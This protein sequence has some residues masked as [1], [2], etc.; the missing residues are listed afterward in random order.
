[1]LVE[2]DAEPTAVREALGAAA[3]GRGRTLVLYG[4]PGIGKSALLLQAV[5]MAP[6]TVLT[7]RGTETESEL[8]FAGL[9]DLLTP[10][11]HLSSEL[12]PP[13]RRAL[14]GALAIEDTG[15]VELFG[16]YAGALT[17][18]SMA[19]EREPLLLCIDDVQWLDAGSAGAL[20]FVAG[21][22]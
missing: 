14:L 17:V 6:G 8:P 21:R 13:Q 4:E 9:R 19:A 10:V 18:L 12:P 22:I 11:L 3:G 16:V 20:R 2:R 5:A 7:T 1:M 15:A